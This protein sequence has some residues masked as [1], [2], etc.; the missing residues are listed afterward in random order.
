KV[1]T[2][3]RQSYGGRYANEL[4]TS[5]AGRGVG[6]SGDGAEFRAARGRCRSGTYRR[7][8]TG[9]EAHRGDGRSGSRRAGAF[10]WPLDADRPLPDGPVW[11]SRSV[12]ESV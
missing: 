12:A 8:Q 2:P 5:G 4:V 7:L 10:S 6:E 1:A 9:V 3:K 11:S